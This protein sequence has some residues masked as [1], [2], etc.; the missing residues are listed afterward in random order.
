MEEFFLGQ[1][2]AIAPVFSEI[3]TIR[4]TTADDGSLFFCGDLFYLFNMQR[5]SAVLGEDVAINIL[6]RMAADSS[7]H[8]SSSNIPDAEAM[9]YSKSRYIQH[10]TE[11]Q[12]WYSSLMDRLSSMKNS[13][14]DINNQIKEQEL[15]EAVAKAQAQSKQEDVSG[16]NSL[17]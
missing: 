12:A 3:E 4:Y 7:M 16:S 10:P 6:K 14:D 13:L 9:A 1:S 5:I 17:E 2:D 8:R 11:I 15:A